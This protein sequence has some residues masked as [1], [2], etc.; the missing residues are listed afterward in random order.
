MQFPATGYVE[1]RD[2]GFKYVPTSYQ[3]KL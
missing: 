2:N 1:P 3:L